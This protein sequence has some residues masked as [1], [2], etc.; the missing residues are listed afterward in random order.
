MNEITDVQTYE[1]DIKLGEAVARLRKNRD[2]KKVVEELYLDGGAI[3][4]AKNINVVKDQDEVVNQIKARGYLYRFLM[5]IEHNA[6]AS[7]EALK[8]SQEEE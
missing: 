3:N 7:I 6:E 2:F 4:L 8:D 1:Q 5:E